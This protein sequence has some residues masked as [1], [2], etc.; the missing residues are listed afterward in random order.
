MPV[1]WGTFAYMIIMS[2]IGMMMY[3][4]KVLDAQVATEETG[5]KFNYKSIGLVFGI[6]VFVPLIIFS[7]Y[8]EGIFDTQDYQ[9]AYT[10]F[11][12]DKLDQI[13]D[14]IL[15]SRDIKRHLFY[16]LLILF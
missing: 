4:N 16:I 15:E 1:W 12:I 3:K 2:S 11:F 7:G 5:G 6:L 8:R 13:Y 9:Y 10:I 14:I